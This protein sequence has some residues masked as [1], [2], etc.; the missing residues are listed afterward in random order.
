[1]MALRNILILK[2][3][4]PG[5]RCARPEDRLRGRLEGR[6]MPIQLPDRVAQRSRVRR[7]DKQFISDRKT[8]AIVRYMF[9]MKL[10][11]RSRLAQCATTCPRLCLLI[12]CRC[13]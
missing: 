11:L 5:P 9:A 3:L 8:A 7:D 10:R 6:T 13:R 12:R 2:R 4:P 1:M